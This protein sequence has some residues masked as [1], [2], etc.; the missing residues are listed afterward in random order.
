MGL[1]SSQARLL[2]LTAQ[3]HNIEYKAQHIMNQKLSLAT[4]QDEAYKTYCDALDATAY[5]VNFGTVNNQKMVD[6]N[7]SSLCKYS[8][9]RAR[10]YVMVDNKSGLVIVDEDMAAKYKKYRN[11]KYAFAYAMMELNPDTDMTSTIGTTV[12]TG[13]NTENVTKYYY[14]YSY[15]AENT[16]ETVKEYYVDTI[17]LYCHEEDEQYGGY[18]QNSLRYFELKITSDMKCETINDCQHKF[19]EYL[20]TIETTGQY[21]SW[22]PANMGND[23]V[24]Y[25]NEWDK[26]PVNKEKIVEYTSTKNE[27]AGP[28][29]STSKRDDD[30]QSLQEKLKDFTVLNTYEESSTTTSV[31]E[32]TITAADVFAELAAASGQPGKEF[33]MDEFNFYCQKWE[34]ID[35]AGGCQVIDSRYETGTEATNWFKKMVESAQ[36]TIMGYDEH[37]A[38]NEWS[39]TSFATSTNENKL[40]EVKDDTGLKKAEAEYE[41]QL[42]LINRKD[43]KY[44]RELKKLE[45]EENALKQQ[46]DSIKKIG[47]ENIDRTFKT[48]Q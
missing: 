45:T 33:L 34:A 11:D 42:N 44:D 1:S 20:D 9:A 3:Q 47:E 24:L 31:N 23:G 41:N 8:D 19:W 25:D 43:S 22:V 26:L 14:N 37:G 18:L 36:I 27:T 30:I 15:T 16:S 32:T 4:E 5:K 48:F 29:T 17:G 12:V 13:T 28:F 2:S 21:S 6:A 40:Q 35:K 7:Y 38:D 46:I 10:N 39:E